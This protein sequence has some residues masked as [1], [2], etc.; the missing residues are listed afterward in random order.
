MA[1]KNNLQNLRSKDTPSSKVQKEQKTVKIYAELFTHMVHHNISLK[2]D[3]KKNISNIGSL[4]KIL[5]G[6][7][8]MLKHLNRFVCYKYNGVDRQEILVTHMANQFN[9]P[10]N[11]IS[12]MI[13]EVSG[14]NYHENEIIYSDIEEIENMLLDLKDAEIFNNLDSS[15]LN[16]NNTQSVDLE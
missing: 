10:G 6:N 13:D 12:R 14:V 4:K 16:E 8:E 5:S 9:L 3:G 2:N 15:S 11:I 7:K 1:K